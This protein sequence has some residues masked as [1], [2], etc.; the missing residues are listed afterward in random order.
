ML[1]TESTGPAHQPDSSDA[2]MQLEAYNSA[3]EAL[4]LNW[5][6]DAVTYA[7]L[8]GRGAQGLRAWLHQE[9]PHLLRAYDADFLV[10]AIEGA[11][12]RCLAARAHRLRG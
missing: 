11:K 12:D 1:A 4:G 5:Q 9:H 6:W 8:P 10:N 3:F 7:C 2:S